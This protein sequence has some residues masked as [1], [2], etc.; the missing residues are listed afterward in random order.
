[1]IKKTISVL[2]LLLFAI[3]GIFAQ[4]F[5][6]GFG[7]GFDED[8][9]EEMEAASGSSITFRSNGEVSVEASPFFKDFMNKNEPL[10]NSFW[11][12]RL[13]LTLSGSSFDIFTNFNFNAG[14]INEI[15][16][17]SENLKDFNYT[18]LI[19][20]E[21]YVR[22]YFGTVNIEFGFRKLTW[23]KADS[24][25]PL[26][27]TNPVDYTNLI[28]ITDIRAR[29]IA[30]PMI[31]AT[32]NT[33]SFSKL[34]GVL[35]PNFAGHRFASDGRWVPSQFSNMVDVA[36]TGII[37]RAIELNPAAIGLI[38]LLQPSIAGNFQDFSLVFPDTSGLEYF[39]AGVRYTTT[40]NFSAGS[41]AD[42]GFQYYY[43]NLFR[44]SF[45]IDGVDEFLVDLLTGNFL[46]PGSYFGDLNL[47][48]PKIKYN[49]Y[50]QIG[51]DYAQVLFDFNIRAELA[52]NLTE[53]L[54]GD[55]GS[56][57]NPFIGWSLG[58]DR[59]LFWGIN[60]NFMCNGTIRLFDSKVG[61]NPVFDA[62]AGTNA[63]FTR[64]SLQ[65]SKNFLRDELESRMVFIWDIENKDVYLIPSVT[66]TSGNLVS[67]LSAGIFAGDKNGELGQYRDNSFLRL[68]LKYMF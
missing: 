31:H 29:K 17:G 36:A 10:D 1:M 2:I 48:D 20:D 65:L 49:R 50:H 55:D 44:P 14:S 6:F 42:F 3:S 47:L 24:A 12:A 32:W 41:S 39:Q 5:G 59:S 58:F 51:I 68:S 27:V 9:D 62:E 15:W 7:F 26:D 66:W 43:G 30:R 63:T 23:G 37:S 57:H 16:S 46:I 67:E 25:G 19:I 61:D 22:A 4:D 56:V 11:N 28:N 60:A 54:K 21:A 8:D 13:N 35:I 33:G 45:T 18:P 38:D 34:E 53:D 64:I 52:L 40:I